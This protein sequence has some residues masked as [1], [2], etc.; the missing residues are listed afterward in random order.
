MR[1]LAL[2]LVLVLVPLVV[3]PWAVTF[4]A[5]KAFALSLGAF[6]L[7][8]K[9]LPR[10][11][12]TGWE[13]F[14]LRWSPL[15]V[16]AAL[17]LATIALAT[18][19]STDP[20]AAGR[21]VAVLAAALVLFMVVENSFLESDEL[22][23]F[24][25]A[26]AL[27]Q[28]LVSGYGLLQ[29]RG[30]DFPFPWTETHPGTPVAT[31]GNPN[32]AAEW[33]AAALPIT[34]LVMLREGG[35]RRFVALLAL[36]AG[37]AFLYVARGRV[38]VA[39]LLLG[40]G[41]AV[42]IALLARGRRAVGALA[43]GAAL[44]VALGG[45]WMLA[46]SGGELPSWAGRS[47][48]VVVRVELA[49]SSAAL[50]AENPLGVGPG[51]WEVAVPPHRSEREVA[52]ALRRDPGE[53]HNDYLQLAAEAGW[54]AVLLGLAALVMLLRSAWTALRRDGADVGASTALLAVVA[55]TLAEAGASAPFHRP[56]SLLLFVFAAAG[57]SFLTDRGRFTAYGRTAVLLHKGVLVLLVGAGALLGSRMMGE[58]AH[59]EGL[60][61]LREGKARE[62]RDALASAATRDPGAARALALAGRVSMTAGVGLARTGDA[63]GAREQLENAW[64]T[65]QRAQALRPMDPAVLVDMAVVQAGF[66]N[67]EKADPLFREALEIAPWHRDAHTSYSGFL[68]DQRRPADALVHATRALELDPLHAPAMGSRFIAIL[69]ADRRADP[70]PEASAA[71]DDLLAAPDDRSE[72]IR[73]LVLRLS[74]E[75]LGMAMMLMGKAR[76]LLA[77][78]DPEG[79]AVIALA[80]VEGRPT[81]DLMNSAAAGLAAAGR[82]VEASQ[83]RV[84]SRFLAAEEALAAGNRNQAL[85]HA[86]RATQIPLGTLAKLRVRV[87][88]AGILVQAGKKEAALV[89]LKTA[90]QRGFKDVDAVLA[91]PAFAPLLEDSAFRSVI[92]GARREK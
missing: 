87:R 40:G 78:P 3:V 71:V 59:A 43:L 17:L 32:F 29:A 57:L 50:L 52:A 54:P 2:L 91:D 53:A 82:K 8:A 21:Q 45:S 63:D 69:R 62:A 92:D 36:L 90:F 4:D 61:L 88:Y 76:R 80:V 47:D 42:G 70:L 18:F 44:A 15:T 16:T 38:A 34:V 73:W 23:P 20:W 6:V 9:A 19:Q 72:D 1:K 84:E 86:E 58:G 77:G 27:V 60:H 14:D 10:R 31:L 55:V 56:A 13:R 51:N 37:G 7:A 11:T 41:A 46:S 35:G 48:T 30:I 75:D 66:K 68:M 79:G 49:K 5:S 39:A 74:R 24:L 89:Q 22:G 85:L 28:G 65:L 67:Y 83:L 26:T 12:E 33:V 25:L 64:R 81:E